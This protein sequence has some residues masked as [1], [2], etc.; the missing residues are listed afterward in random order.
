MLV[1]TL[2]SAV[3]GVDAMTVTV[4]A[5]VGPGVKMAMV[6]LPDNAVRESIDR[7]KT[8]IQHNHYQW[9]K[10]RIVIN[11][12]PADVRK[13]GSAYDLCLAIS[14]MATNGQIRNKDLS[15]YMI[16]GELS[17]DGSVH[18]VRGVLPIA[19]HARKL[20]M[21]GFLLPVQNASEAAIVKDL[22]I[23]PVR[24]LREAVD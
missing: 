3:Q 15:Q 21:Q 13:E 23:I 16:M 6:G 20:G 4:E 12:A 14:I 7:I 1:K 24:H 9:P 8:A 22:D 19:M 2:G 5:T 10:G 18:P 17:L 11:M